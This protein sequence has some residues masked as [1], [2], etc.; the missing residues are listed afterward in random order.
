MAK[1]LEEDPLPFASVL[2]DLR[3]PASLE[4]VVLKAMAKDRTQRHANTQALKADLEKISRELFPVTAT[5][6]QPTGKPQASPAAE[7]VDPSQPLDEEGWKPLELPKHLASTFR[8]SGPA[9]PEEPRAT[10][11]TEEVSN[12]TQSHELSQQFRRSAET[13]AFVGKQTG[14]WRRKVDKK[15]HPKVT[16]EEQQCQMPTLELMN[17]L[18]DDFKRYAYHF[19]LTEENRQL[20]VT[21]TLPRK[22]F[23]LSV[24]GQIENSLWVISAVGHSDVLS[25][26]FSPSEKVKP[27]TGSKSEEKVLFVE[28]KSQAMMFGR[29]FWFIDNHPLFVG[30]LPSLSK[31]IFARLRRVSVNEVDLNE[32]F[33]FNVSQPEL[34]EE[35]SEVEP[36]LTQSPMEI[37]TYSLIAALDALNEELM[38][39]RHCNAKGVESEHIAK[40]VVEKT[41]Q[42]ENLQKQL[43]TVAEEWVKILET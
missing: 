26:Y 14:S 18:F 31:K 30:H 35:T 25:F 32:A 21:C 43:T 33:D 22:G 1:L 37:I 2:A 29:K 6:A 28:L 7:T 8:P 17:R 42:L 12:K 20:M 5:T 4:Q 15:L 10:R 19:N 41:K 13:R 38:F 40:Q 3:I 9:E 16:P 23:D 34:E 27:K 11:S 36:Q 39:L 24:R